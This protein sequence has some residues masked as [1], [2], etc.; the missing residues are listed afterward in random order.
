MIYA[1]IA[2][3]RSRFFYGGREIRR[4][5]E[6]KGKGKKNILVLHQS[7]TDFNKFAGEIESSDLPRAFDYYAIGY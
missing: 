4:Q 6:K 1:V 2:L 3:E 5:K 7:L